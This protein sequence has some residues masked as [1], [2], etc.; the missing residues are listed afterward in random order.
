MLTVTEMKSKAREVVIT[1]DTA[2]YVSTSAS[3]IKA[4]AK[5]IVSEVEEITDRIPVAITLYTTGIR[6]RDVGFEVPN[7]SVIDYGIAMVYAAHILFNSLGELMARCRTTM[8]FKPTTK[9]PVIEIACDLDEN[10][11]TILPFHYDKTIGDK[12]LEW[13]HPLEPA[14]VPATRNF[15]KNPR[16]TSAVKSAAVHTEQFEVLSA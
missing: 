8:K 14:A 16:R 10:H 2:A 9:S 13:H 1:V 6:M 7:P 12:G 11:M 15:P 5:F 3:S 4:A